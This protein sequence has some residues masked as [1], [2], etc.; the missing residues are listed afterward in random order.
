MRRYITVLGAITASAAILALAPTWF[1][2]EMP[3]W[4][5]AADIRAINDTLEEHGTQIA[6]NTEAGWL[7]QL[8][9]ALAR[10]D[11]IAVRRICNIISKL[12][13]YRAADCP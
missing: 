1:G 6:G 2:W 13:G 12:Y 4:A 10:R 9:N 8:E 3:P 11:H 5:K 7:R